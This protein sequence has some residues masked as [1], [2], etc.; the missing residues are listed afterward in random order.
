MSVFFAR[1]R[2]ALNIQTSIMVSSSF[3]VCLENHG[4]IPA[5]DF[6]RYTCYPYSALPPHFFNQ[7]SCQLLDPSPRFVERYSVNGKKGAGPCRTVE[8]EKK[9]VKH[10]IDI[11]EIANQFHPQ[12]G[13]LKTVRPTSRCRP[14]S[15]CMRLTCDDAVAS[16]GH[17]LTYLPIG[18]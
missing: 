15:G 8:L 4:N 17:R 6:P 18:Y 16:R 5:H 12:Y 13:T 11:H 7:N 9:K 10:Y 1:D 2:K 14:S 3:K